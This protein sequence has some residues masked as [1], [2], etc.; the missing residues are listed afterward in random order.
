MLLGR[1]QG[2]L[3]IEA[4]LLSLV[5]N[6]HCKKLWMLGRAWLLFGITLDPNIL[7]INCVRAHEG[8]ER[9]SRIYQKIK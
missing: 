9:T 3:D 2:L 6:M 1:K 5:F 7:R 4:A 8:K